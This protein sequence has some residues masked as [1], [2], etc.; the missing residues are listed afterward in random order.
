M[1][2]GPRERC[3]RCQRYRHTPDPASRAPVLSGLISA[4]PSVWHSDCVSFDSRPLWTLPAD[5]LIPQVLTL[6][7]CKTCFLVLGTVVFSPNTNACEAMVSSWNYWEL[8]GSLERKEVRSLK[9]CRAFGGKP[10][11]LTF[12]PSLVMLPGCHEMNL[13]IFLSRNLP[14]HIASSLSHSNGA[15]CPWVKTPETTSRNSLFFL[16]I[17]C[18]RHFFLQQQKAD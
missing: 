6:P 7:C 5:S 12:P 1:D 4:V 2:Q 8:V 10:W 13:L 14:W 11:P 18:S 9:V 16:Y 17:G 15:K 3:C